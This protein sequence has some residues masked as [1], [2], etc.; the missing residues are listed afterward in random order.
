MASK[1]KPKA[2][3]RPRKLP[4]G[5]A[6]SRHSKAIAGVADLR[7]RT[8]A[9][10]E[11][12]FKKRFGEDFLPQGRSS[13]VGGWL[14]SMW[15]AEENRTRTENEARAIYERARRAAARGT[16]RGL[17]PDIEAFNDRT[18]HGSGGIAT[19]TLMVILDT[20]ARGTLTIDTPG[21]LPPLKEI[22]ARHYKTGIG[23][24][25][26]DDGF[27]AL[28]RTIVKEAPRPPLELD[29]T[30]R[31]IAIMTI[32][33]GAAPNWSLYEDRDALLSPATVIRDVETR[34]RQLVG[35]NA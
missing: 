4:T 17:L 10:C 11:Q 28:V 32:L 5:A 2:R 26:R 30:N 6:V 25:G 33:C 13:L 18:P 24:W 8:F 23:E 22:A 15:E 16:L 21:R 27:T 12:E 29:V 35:S 20:V 3:K 9:T 7:A 1:K 34:V 19:T 14:I 31:D